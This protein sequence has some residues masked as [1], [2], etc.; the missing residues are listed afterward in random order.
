MKLGAQKPRRPSPTQEQTTLTPGSGP[1][2]G[3]RIGLVGQAGRV[4]V[5]RPLTVPSD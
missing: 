2:L 5:N 4:C 3:L 1:G